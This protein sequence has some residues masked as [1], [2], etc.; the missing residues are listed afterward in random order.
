MASRSAQ[1]IKKYVIADSQYCEQ[2][3][4]PLG[5]TIVPRRIIDASN[6][7]LLCQRSEIIFQR[8]E[9]ERTFGTVSLTE[10]R[11]RTVPAPSKIFT[12]YVFLYFDCRL[13]S[14]TIS[15]P[16]RFY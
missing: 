10:F 6:D 12:G 1:Q 8:S 5:A 2:P 14:Q 7:E 13:F 4:E 11:V 15:S 3:P 9:A 16:I